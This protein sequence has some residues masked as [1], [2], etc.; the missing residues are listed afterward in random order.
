MWT[1]EFDRVASDLLA[2]EWTFAKT[3]PRDPHWYTLRKRWQ[4][5]EAFERAVRYLRRVGYRQTYRRAR[6]AYSNINEHCYWTMGWPVEETELINRAVW[7]GEHPYDA[8]MDGY[9]DRYADPVSV[10]ESEHVFGELADAN[11]RSVLDLGC[12]TGMLLDYATP[13]A[14]LG[15]DPSRVALDILRAKHP[16]VDVMR[17]RLAWLHV[18]ERSFDVLLAL[19]GVGSYLAPQ[20]L[21]RIPLMAPRYLVMFYAPDYSPTFPGGVR[22]PDY[23]LQYAHLLPGRRSTVG[24]FLVV[25]S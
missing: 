16:H 19:F 24:N 17:T 2:Q 23:G 5:D 15:I 7:N 18:P 12:G 14:Y 8:V 9:D 1:P 21:E 13:A 3:M 4:E 22:I 6:Y 25:E 20:E 10:A 11:G